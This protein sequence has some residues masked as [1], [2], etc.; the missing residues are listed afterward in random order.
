MIATIYCPLRRFVFDVIQNEHIWQKHAHSG[1]CTAFFMTGQVRRVKGPV[2]STVIA[3]VL[4]LL[5][6]RRMEPIDMS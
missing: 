3:T 2:Q 1:F 5:F 4:Y 6:P